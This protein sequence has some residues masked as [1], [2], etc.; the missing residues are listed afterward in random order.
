MGPATKKGMERLAE[1]T[2]LA[3]FEAIVLPH[4]DSA[5]NLARWLCRDPDEAQDIVQEATMRALR[6]FASYRGED[7]RPWYLKIVRN[8]FLSGRG[9]P[10]GATVLPFSALERQDGPSVVEQVPAPPPGPARPLAPA[11]R[12]RARLGARG[13]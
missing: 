13:R 3:R 12:P 1:P 9:R 2:D 10:G 4:L 7:A 8:T 6:F 11:R 5:Y